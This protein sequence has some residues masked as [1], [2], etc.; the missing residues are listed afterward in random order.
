MLVIA[1]EITKNYPQAN[2]QLAV[3]KG[4]NLTV[5]NGEFVSVVGESGA[6]KTTLLQIIG[7]LDKPSSGTLLIDETAPLKLP[8]QKL[9]NYR[10]RKIG[11]IFQLHHLL[12]EFTVAENIALPVL[13]ATNNRKKA[14]GQ[15][16]ELLKRFSLEEKEGHYPHELSGGE[17]QRI[18]VLRAIAN[19]PQLLIADEP[20]GNLDEDNARRFEELLVN[21]NK[22]GQTIILATHN[23]QFAKRAKRKFLLAGGIIKEIE[24]M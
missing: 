1:K 11:F 9:S 10:N 23:L 8:E 12:P 22:E 21:L 5:E 2:G 24:G 3:L 6:G 16:C 18:A 15:A 17:R 19:K 4:V 13:M 14:L 20:T 7:L